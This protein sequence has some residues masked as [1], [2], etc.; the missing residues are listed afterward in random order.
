[1]PHFDSRHQHS[2]SSTTLE[3]A[4]AQLRRIKD[5]L[6]QSFS[7]RP[8]DQYIGI[9]RSRSATKLGFQK[10]LEI[11]QT[12]GSSKIPL[13][14][15]MN[16]APET[17]GAAERLF[18][19]GQ[20]S[21]PQANVA[22]IFV[23]AGAGYHSTTNEHIHL[24][25]CDS[26]ARMAMRVL[27]AGGTAV[28]AVEA[29]IKV[30]EDKEI[31]NAGYGSNLAIDGVVE[32][33]ATIVDYLGRS[34]ACGATAQIKNPI[35][36][37]RSILDASSRPLS[38]RRVPPN[39][40][41][42]QGATDFAWEHGIPVVPHE[43]LVSRNARDRYVRWR[44]DL[45][46]VESGGR[47][48][49][50]SSANSSQAEE[51][52]LDFEYEERIRAKQRRD[53]TL[54]I[55]NGTWNEGQ[56]DSPSSSPQVTPALTASRELCSQDPCPAL[57]SPSP[58]AFPLS[59]TR[60]RGKSPT[61]QPAKR[62][63]YGEE[64]RTHSLL[65]PNGELHKSPP[66]VTLTR[67]EFLLKEPSNNPNGSSDGYQSPTSDTETDF[68]PSRA[69]FE[70]GT[71]ESPSKPFKRA[72]EDSI[73][74]TVGAI[75]IDMFGHIAAGSSSGGIG[76]KHRGR[77]GPAALVGIGSAVIPADDRDEEEVAVAAVTS[78]TGEHMATTM[79]SQKCAERLY[80]NTRR[81]EGGADIEATEEEA[82]ISFVQADFMSHPGVAGSNSSGAIGVMAVKKTPGG[83]FLHFAHNT[84]SF[85]LASMHSREREA[86]CVMSRLGDHG[87]VV[88]GGRKIR[89]D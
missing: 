64:R 2:Q 57:R 49:P 32:C 47:G 1:M 69:F 51:E 7:S 4:R 27:N 56:P 35:H 28:D 86:K 50:G 65:G 85:A 45:R 39:L 66:D 42:G 54:A 46:R 20:S 82:M 74:D 58:S 22:A 37:A 48:T 68:T 83:Y 81:A 88:Q 3:A 25:A 8:Q 44:E 59:N 77:V 31:T 14:D 19:R 79:A 62:P 23:H 73:T 21:N 36:L 52:K 26:A 30:L 71:A 78:G 72:D 55:L 76:M 34:G 75:A 80:H 18:R 63:R 38:L 11:I 61:G 53:H 60:A 16:L 41:V 5:S 9:A 87:S 15:T 84:D 10:G 13:L 29:A 24:G 40:L 89:V 12:L 17:D 6:R 33:D 70:E 43:M 67:S